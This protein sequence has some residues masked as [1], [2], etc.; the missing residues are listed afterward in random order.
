[1]KNPCW[2]GYRAYG[3][4]KKNGKRVPNCVPTNEELGADNEWGTPAL[5]RKMLKV[6]PGQGTKMKSFKSFIAVR[7]NMVDMIQYH[8]TLNPIAWVNDELKID[9]RAALMKIADNFMQTWTY[10][11]PVEDIILTGSNANYNWTAF[12]DFDLHI[13]ID[14]KKVPTASG[15]FVRDY[16]QTKKNIWNKVHNV[17]IK[18]YNVELYVQDTGEPLVA[19][20]IYSLLKNTWITKP[21][22]EIPNI[23]HPAIQTKVSAYQKDI[24]EVVNSQDAEKLQDMLDKI[25]TLRKTG[26]QSGGEYSIENLAF[27][28]LR[29]MG[30]IDK[31][32]SMVTTAYDKNLSLN[33]M[34]DHKYHSIQDFIRYAVDRL[35]LDTTPVINF[36]DDTAQSV[37]EASLGGFNFVTKEISVSTNKRL[38][39]DIL[40]TIAHEMVHFK[41]DAENAL[42]EEDGETGSEVENEAN[43]IAG[44]LLRDYGKTNRKIYIE[45]MIYDQ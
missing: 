42:T 36:I 18:G 37:E 22:K 43:S 32:R 13:I 26:L 6:T 21:V 39:A 7:E 34:T 17:M 12:S 35:E 16:M 27:K 38:T 33:E 31:L 4:K 44:I 24:E 14:M 3:V 25:S 41:Q 11:I 2:S 30:E 28:V 1:M 40:R 23:N 45:S 8:P 10:D 20:G 29:N 19:T 9:V 5:T 15:Q